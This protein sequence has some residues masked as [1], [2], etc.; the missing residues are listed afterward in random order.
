METARNNNTKLVDAGAM[1]WTYPFPFHANSLDNRHKLNP[2]MQLEESRVLRNDQRLAPLIKIRNGTEC[3]KYQ[4]PWAHSCGFSPL[5][6]RGSYL[7]RNLH[8]ELLFLAENLSKFYLRFS[9]RFSPNKRTC[10]VGGDSSN[11]WGA[12]PLEIKPGLGFFNCEAVL[13]SYFRSLMVTDSGSMNLVLDLRLPIQ[14]RGF[15]IAGSG[16]PSNSTPLTG[17]Q[18]VTFRFSTNLSHA[19]YFIESKS[20]QMSSASTGNCYNS[21]YGKLRKFP[22]KRSETRQRSVHRRYNIRI[23]LCNAK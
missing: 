6:C 14:D 19:L 8:N 3:K 16:S 1:S 17:K 11:W 22:S 23:V 9:R 10:V 5:V 20:S 2:Q 18:F 7:E 15:M 13:V 4:R 21:W 12:L